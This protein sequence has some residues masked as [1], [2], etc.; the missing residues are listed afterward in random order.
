MLPDVHTA[1]RLAE[2]VDG[3]YLIA[4]HGTDDTIVQVTYSCRTYA[5]VPG[6]IAY[7]VGS[8]NTVSTSAPKDCASYGITWSP[9]PLPSPG[10]PGSR[11]RL[12]F[13]G[14]GY[15]VSSNA[16]QRR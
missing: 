5:A 11:Y 12:V 13:N 9:C 6:V 3:T 15:E 8:G 7:H 4:V 14:A 1:Q 10:Y 2:A 16:G